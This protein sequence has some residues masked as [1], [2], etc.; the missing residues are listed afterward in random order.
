MQHPQSCSC[1]PCY[2]LQIC[3]VM[4]AACDMTLFDENLPSWHHYTG[5]HL[6]LSLAGLSL[7]A[8]FL[9]SVCMVQAAKPQCSDARPG[10]FSV[11]R[12]RGPSTK[13]ASFTLH[14]FVRPRIIVCLTLLPV[15]VL[16]R[17]CCQALSA[18]AFQVQQETAQA[19][20]QQVYRQAA[21]VQQVNHQAAAVQQVNHQ[22]AAESGSG[23]TGG[24]DKIKAVYAAHD[25]SRFM[26]DVQ[27]KGR[28]SR[29]V[30]EQSTA[31]AQAHKVLTDV[32]PQA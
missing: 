17:A 1:K 18:F 25:V 30:T 14:K 3:S 29:A 5:M 9:S 19:A 15:S 7:A 21:A 16:S 20:V 13:G 23:Y 31:H 2:A 26:P 12:V 27:P 8:Q 4:S 10:T 24:D 32:A 28:T 6:S 11:W 22:A